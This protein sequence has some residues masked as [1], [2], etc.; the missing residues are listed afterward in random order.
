MSQFIYNKVP[1]NILLNGN[2]IMESVLN[3]YGAE[4]WELICF[5]WWKDKLAFGYFKKRVNS[6]AH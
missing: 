2:E 1:A 5:T 6:K 4:G 3:K